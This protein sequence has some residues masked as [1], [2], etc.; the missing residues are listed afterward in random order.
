M[1]K[2][3]WMM[4]TSRKLKSVGCT[5]EQKVRYA[6]YLLTGLA[7]TWWEELNYK[8]PEEDIITWTDCRGY[9]PGYTKVPFLMTNI[10][11]IQVIH[12]CRILKK[13]LYS[14]VGPDY[15]SLGRNI[16]FWAGTQQPRPPYNVLGQN[17]LLS[18]LGR[19]IL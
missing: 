4:D 14:K 16:S 17:K 2:E 18:W 12:M 5:E 8:W 15:I 7:A 6:G 13:L 3:H 11:V 19:H 10:Y 1:E 9:N